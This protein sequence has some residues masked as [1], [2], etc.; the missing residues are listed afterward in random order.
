ML[1]ISFWISAGLSV[2]LGLAYSAI[3]WLPAL[4]DLIGRD[5]SSPQRTLDRGWAFAWPWPLA[6]PVIC[7]MIGVTWLIVTLLHKRSNDR[8][9]PETAARRTTASAVTEGKPK[10]SFDQLLMASA[11]DLE[12]PKPMTTE[13]PAWAEDVPDGPNA[14]TILAPRDLGG[15]AQP[16][17]PAPV[18]LAGS[19]PSPDS[20][21]TTP[22][23]PEIE[24]EERPNPEFHNDPGIA[25][26][27][28]TPQMEASG[29]AGSAKPVDDAEPDM[30]PADI[31]NDTPEPAMVAGPASPI[32]G[33][34]EV[35]RF[36]ADRA[37]ISEMASWVESLVDEVQSPFEQ[38]VAAGSFDVGAD[39]A[40]VRVMYLRMVAAAAEQRV[41]EAQKT[42]FKQG[43]AP[44]VV[45]LVLM[46]GE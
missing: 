16:Q 46:S 1:K 33:I 23:E 27:A 32:P 24:A 39:P 30:A 10:S 3:Y 41:C 8:Q 25:E 5:L 4:G 19:T 6:I 38:A 26:V 15:F 34:A 17:I 35:K 2:L 11:A 31:E 42:A 7:A 45:D 21:A 44:E 36:L 22:D 40:V 9:Q 13:L 29:D 12:R 28:E 43:V 37:T 14:S 18:A 20:K